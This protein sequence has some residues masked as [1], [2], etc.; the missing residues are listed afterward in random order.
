MHITWGKVMFSH[1][2]L[3]KGGVHE[4]LGPTPYLQDRIELPLL[5]DR[6]GWPPPSLPWKGQ[7]DATSPPDGTEWPS[8]LLPS[9]YELLYGHKPKTQMSSS[10][11]D[12]QSRHPDNENHQEK[13]YK[14]NKD[15]LKPMTAKPVQT[16]ECWIIWNQCM[17]EPPSRKFWNEVLS[18]IDQTSLENQEPILLT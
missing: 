9:P 14:G 5:L 16:K 8:L 12:L 13:N 15:K 10:Q 2:I 3:L 6:T 4:P 1:V 7:D 11:K 17:S 18:S